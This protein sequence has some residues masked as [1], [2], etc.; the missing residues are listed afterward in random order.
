MIMCAYAPGSTVSPKNHGAV[1]DIK[2]G[3][4]KGKQVLNV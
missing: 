3:V 4:S 2:A 1:G